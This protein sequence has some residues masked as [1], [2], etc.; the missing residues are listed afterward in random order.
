MSC[1]SEALGEG[2]ESSA[3]AL[4]V[5]AAEFYGGGT[6]YFPFWRLPLWAFTSIR[7]FEKEEE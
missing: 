7:S 6:E 4:R 3:C 5:L 2:R 1:S